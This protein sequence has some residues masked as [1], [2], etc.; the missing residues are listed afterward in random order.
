MAEEEVRQPDGDIDTGDWTTPPLWSK[1]DEGS[2]VPDGIYIICPNNKN[3][4]FECTVQDPTNPGTYTAVQIKVYARKSA[5]GGNQRGLDADI[6]IGGNLQ[7][8]QTLNANLT[9][10]W[11]EYTYT[12]SGLNFTKSQMNTLQILGIS[13]GTTGGSPSNRREVHIDYYETILT[14]TPGAPKTTQYLVGNDCPEYPHEMDFMADK[15]PCP[16]P[17]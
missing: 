11:T 13:T 17:Y 12:W 16:P 4:S 7:G 15:M 14:Y 5:T 8:Q 3:S 2:G 9:A 6:K 1:I 10:T